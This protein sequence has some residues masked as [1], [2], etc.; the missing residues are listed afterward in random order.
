MGLGAGDV[1]DSLALSDVMPVPSPFNPRRY[2]NRSDGQ[3]QPGI[4]QALYT[5]AQSPGTI[6]HT[7]FTGLSSV[8]CS[9]AAI[10]LVANDRV[11]ALD[12]MHSWQ[13]PP[14]EVPPTVPGQPPR[15]TPKQ[16]RMTVNDP[17]YTILTSSVQLAPSQGGNVLTEEVM[18][19][20]WTGSGPSGQEVPIKVDGWVTGDANTAAWIGASDF[21]FV[22][23]AT[24]PVL[25]VTVNVPGSVSVFEPSMFDYG[26]YVPFDDSSL[27]KLI[28]DPEG[29]S[30]E[31]RFNY[32]LGGDPSQPALHL[33]NMVGEMNPNLGYVFADVSIDMWDPVIT[34]FGFEVMLQRSFYGSGST[35]MAFNGPIDTEALLFTLQFGS[36]T[37][38]PEPSALMLLGTAALGLLGLALY[39]Q[40]RRR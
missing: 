18:I 6:Y 37:V 26:T 23:D 19:E 15:I 7:D 11:N 33:F 25:P 17:T 14:P 1:I 40:R 20:P 2:I 31:M 10:G 13:T 12:V 39:G 28:V 29:T 38:V 27:Y 35:A 34:M 21:V 5:L 4:D 30:F 32:E 36:L 9:A 16:W 24:T 3:V 22:P 8:F